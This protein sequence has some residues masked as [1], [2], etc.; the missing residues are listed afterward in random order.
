MLFVFLAAGLGRHLGYFPQ[1][2]L[3]HTAVL[4]IRRSLHMAV[5]AVAEYRLF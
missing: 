2:N 5:A 3:R 1:K 4:E